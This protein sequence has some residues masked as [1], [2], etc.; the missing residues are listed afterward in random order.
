MRI[1]AFVFNLLE[2]L[3]RW[4]QQRLGRDRLAWLFVGPNLLVFGVFTFLPIVINFFYASSGGVNLMPLERPFTGLENFQILLECGNYLD[5]STCRK[6]VFWRALFNTLKF[7]LLQVGLMV[8]FSLITALVLNRKIVGRGFWRGVF[9]YPVLLSPVVDLEMD[10]A[11]SGRFQCGLGGFRSAGRGMV[12]QRL[13]GF[14]LD[15]VRL[16]LGAHGVLHFDFAGGPASH[17]Q[18]PV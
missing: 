10:A 6:D 13:M 8:L 7:T 14:F 11:K 18:R 16:H 4:A 1:F 3:F 17:S 9:F 15:G 5:L 12:D 2:P